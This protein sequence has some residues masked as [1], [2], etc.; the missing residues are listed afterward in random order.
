MRTI[1]AAF[2]PDI[3]VLIASGAISGIKHP[4]IRLHVCLQVSFMVLIY[5]TRDR[6]PGTIEC[7]DTLHVVAFQ[8][9]RTPHPLIP[10][11][12]GGD[13]IQTDLA[14]DGVQDD[15]LDAEERNGSGARLRFNSS[16]E[17]CQDD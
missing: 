5:S 16:G 17:R 6:W 3:T 1:N 12:A 7:E 14:A 2:D 4:R 13:I 10:I 8:H 9:L 15:R 11:G